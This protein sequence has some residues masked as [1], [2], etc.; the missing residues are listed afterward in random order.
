M[1]KL[2]R[3]LLF[4]V[5]FLASTFSASAED[6]QRDNLVIMMDCS[7]SMGGEKLEKAKNALKEILAHVPS[8]TD[9][10]LVSF[11]ANSGWNYPLG[12]RKNSQLMQAI[13]G[14][15]SGGDTPLGAYMK[16]G[17]DRLLEQKK[18]QMGYGTFRLLVITDGEAQ[19][20][21]L[22]DLYAPEIMRKGI[23]LDVIGVF[24]AE[25]HTLSRVSHSYREA[26]DTQSLQK[27]I[28]EVLAEI[29]QSPQASV[30][31][32]A[33]LE[34]GGLPDEMVPAIITALTNVPEGP[35]AGQLLGRSSDMK[36]VSNQTAAP[37]PTSSWGYFL[38]NF[39]FF[40]IIAVVVLFQIIKNLKR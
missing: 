14:L 29:G 19:N 15:A 22:V 32:E 2:L 37:P 9:I 30:T 21:Q 3:S 35:I 6:L 34:I 33:F 26:Q 40:V 36:L 1:R 27:A 13:D 39:G 10:G 20:P 4:A 5:C 38:K 24:M 17:A 7:G 16:M 18:K 12:P 8:N 31:H 11:G 25:Q 28:T 23:T